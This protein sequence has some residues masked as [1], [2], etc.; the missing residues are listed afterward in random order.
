[1][2]S[3][4]KMEESIDQTE[5]AKAVSEKSEHFEVGSSE[6]M[7]QFPESE[8]GLEEESNLDPSESDSDQL[9]PSCRSLVI[10]QAENNTPFWYQ[11]KGEV[12][13]VINEYMDVTGLRFVSYSKTATFLK[14][15][16]HDLMVSLVVGEMGRE[17]D[18]TPPPPIIPWHLYT[19]SFRLGQTICP[20]KGQR[21][22][23]NEDSRIASEETQREPRISNHIA[24][25][26]ILS[27]SNCS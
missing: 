19:A 18:V 23:F 21:C 20:R 12:D 16:E 2:A 17:K 7:V 9:S 22:I 8:I 27:C 26:T 25:I 4:A 15:G 6:K 5:P 3:N 14:H 13:R 24:L 10:V 1:M 11:L